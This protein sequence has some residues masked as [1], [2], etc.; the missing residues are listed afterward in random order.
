VGWVSFVSPRLAN[1]LSPFNMF[2]GILGEAALTIW[3][4]AV[5]VNVQRWNESAAKASKSA[6]LSAT[7]FL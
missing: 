1:Q 4:L 6:S 7:Y 5:G 2:P 3:L